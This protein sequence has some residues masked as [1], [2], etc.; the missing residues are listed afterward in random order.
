MRNWFSF[1]INDAI[2]NGNIGEVSTCRVLRNFEYSLGQQ[3]R[4]SGVTLVGISIQQFVVRCIDVRP[5]MT[6]KLLAPMTRAT[7]RSFPITE[8]F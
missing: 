3:E 6:Q 4:S 5:Q 7:K 1:Q 8:G 2:T